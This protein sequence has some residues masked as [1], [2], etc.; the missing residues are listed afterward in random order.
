MKFLVAPLDNNKYQF[1]LFWN[2]REESCF[3]DGVIPL[4]LLYALCEQLP[5]EIKNPDT[6]K[7]FTFDRSSELIAAYVINSDGGYG[8]FC[9]IHH[10]S[11][12]KFLA[13][14]YE[15]AEYLIKTSHV[16][17]DEIS[18]ALLNDSS[19][20]YTGICE[21]H[22]FPIQYEDDDYDEDDYDEDAVDDDD[23]DWHDDDEFDFDKD[24]VDEKSMD[25]EDAKEYISRI[26]STIDALY[27]LV[28][29]GKRTE[30]TGEHVMI[31]CKTLD[32][33]FV[34][35]KLLQ[36]EN[37]Q[38]YKYQNFYYIETNAPIDKYICTISE[39]GCE[40]VTK[41]VAAI[42]EH[43]EMLPADNVKLLVR[44]S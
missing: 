36:N 40:I 29:K 21:K 5:T 24:F 3:S 32:C 10:L 8:I 44:C 14:I 31:S 20:Y 18:F 6:G 34:I 41:N 1:K 26:K 37:I 19:L 15:C 22:N 38:I 17:E 43:G 42:R 7:V 35:V 12:E 4:D 33:L 28:M 13:C 2:K 16:G 27:G 39:F 23:V 11:E 9:G 30:N 25:T